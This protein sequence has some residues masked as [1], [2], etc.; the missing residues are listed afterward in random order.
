M[1]YEGNRL[2][3]LCRYR[4]DNWHKTYTFVASSKSVLFVFRHGYIPVGTSENH[5][6]T[7]AEIHT[8]YFHVD[9]EVYLTFDDG[10]TPGIT[11]WILDQLAEYDA[12]AT[13]FC[14]GKNAEQYPHLFRMIVEDGHAIGNHTYSHQKGWSMSVESYIEDVEFEYDI[15]HTDL[16]RPPYARITPS[17]ARRLSERYNLIMWDVLS[18]D[19]SPWV[20]PRQCLH[21]VTRYVRGGSIVVFHDS[22]KS[23]RNL[24]YA[25]PRTLQYLRDNDLKCS[26]IEL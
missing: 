24:R 2:Q 4:F 26:I 10:P 11:E 12:K 16:F 17:Q 6:H 21:N 18:R 8:S 19:Y 15:L 7:T 20:S 23:F 25:L 1:F 3:T 13:F 9:G 5:A 22:V 14:L